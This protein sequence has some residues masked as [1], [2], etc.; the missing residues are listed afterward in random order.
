MYA[1]WL[2]VS[3]YLAFNFETN[4]RISVRLGIERR[5]VRKEERI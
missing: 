3:V 5:T 2:V 1:Y 4:Q